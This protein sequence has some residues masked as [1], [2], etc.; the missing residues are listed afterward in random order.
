VSII[1]QDIVD[2]VRVALREELQPPREELRQI[3]EELRQIQQGIV[4]IKAE[5]RRAG[6][7]K[8]RHKLDPRHVAIAKLHIDNPAIEVADVLIGM[9]RARFRDPEN[10]APLPSWGIKSWQEMT[11]LID[12]IKRMKGEIK[13]MKGEIKRTKKEI[14]KNQIIKNE[15]IKKEKVIKNMRPY[16]GK[17]KAKV[18]ANPTYYGLPPKIQKP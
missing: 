3:R 1:A 16:I 13:R 17:I 12:E 14:D 18:K 8:R 15:I 6:P 7:T 10:L 11:R 4:G 2:A 5:L 9:D